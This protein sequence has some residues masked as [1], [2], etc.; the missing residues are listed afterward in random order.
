MAKVIC[1]ANQKGGVGKT[2]TAINLA[3]S[4]AAAQKRTMF[5][6]FDPQANATSGVGVDKE[7]VRRSIYDALIG[8][9]EI[10]DIKI[11]V[12]PEALGGFLSVVPATPELTGAEVELLHLEDREWRLKQAI[13]KVVHEYD[14][15]L[16][17]CPPSLSILTVNALT[18]ADSVL[19]PVQCEYYAMEGLGQLQR[20]ISLIRQRLNPELKVEGY[21][22]TM[23]DS[24]NRIC[25]V[26]ANELR[27]YFNEEVFESVIFR[28]VRLAE[29][30][31][32]GKPI[33]LYDIKSTGAESYVSL[34]REVI[35]RNGGGN[36]EESHTG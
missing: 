2:T 14:F 33:I 22:L 25:H 21:L 17:D 30:P 32:H 23:F 31:S 4:L 5:I 34:A 15:I 29:S 20:T 11:D 19:I 9:A 24:R 7:E 28:N 8:E 26:V 16:I 13:E 6:D 12:E 18:A 35:A 1:I 3:A 10:A 36:I 27:A